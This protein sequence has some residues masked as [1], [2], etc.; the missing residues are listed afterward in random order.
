MTTIPTP[1]A[2]ASVESA[3]LPT[4][5][6]RP[7]ADVVIFDGECRIC[8]AQIERVARWDSRGRLAYLSLHEPVVA[9][10]FPDL[11]YD[12]MMRQMYLVDRRGGRHGGAAALRVIAR[13][14]PRLWPLVPLLSLPGTLP[15]WQWLYQQV[16][17]RRYRLGGKHECSEGSCKLHER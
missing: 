17:K 3:V 9:R 15:L 5:D 7:E 10:R 12:D 14:L 6:E 13:R 4:P 11:S 1:T 2:K 8:R 16:A